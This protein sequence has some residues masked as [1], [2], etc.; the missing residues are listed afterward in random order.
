ML[1][2]SLRLYHEIIGPAGSKLTSCGLQP[3]HGG[4]ASLTCLYPD[5]LHPISACY[6]RST[7]LKSFSIYSVLVFEG[8]LKLQSARDLL[9]RAVTYLPSKAASRPNR[10]VSDPGIIDPAALYIPTP[11][12]VIS[13][14]TRN[15]PTVETFSFSPTYDALSS[16]VRL[17]LTSQFFQFLAV[18]DS[19]FGAAQ[20]SLLRSQ[21]T[22][23]DNQRDPL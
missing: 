10:R 20:L 1:P 23:S 16:L 2:C 17:A 18:S 14:S 21:D 15:F 12:V 22:P 5:R 4:L 7:R 8:F 11:A 9:K 6:F 13:R 19:S 3:S